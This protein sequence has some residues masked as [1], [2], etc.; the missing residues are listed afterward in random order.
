MAV[1]WPCDTMQVPGVGSSFKLRNYNYEM[2]RN[3][4]KSKKNWGRGRRK[5]WKGKKKDLKRI[6]CKQY[7]LNSGDG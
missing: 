1:Y 2:G 4:L 5:V 7:F 3:C 6:K